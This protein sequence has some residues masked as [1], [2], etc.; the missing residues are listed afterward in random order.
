[1]LY[2]AET[3]GSCR[4]RKGTTGSGQSWQRQLPAVSS[5]LGAAGLHG[6]GALARCHTTQSRNDQHGESPCSIRVRFPD[7]PLG[8]ACVGVPSGGETPCLT[9]PLHPRTSQPG[10]ALPNSGP[11]KPSGSNPGG[12]TVRRE[13][14]D[15]RLD[16]PSGSKSVSISQSGRPRETKRTSRGQFPGVGNDGYG[17]PCGNRWSETVGGRFFQEAA[18]STIPYRARG[19]FTVFSPFF[20]VCLC[21]R[22]ERTIFL[23]ANRRSTWIQAQ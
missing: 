3:A 14:G 9:T 23:L 6:W 22:K 5:F 19:K 7:A 1:M 17:R 8:V 11:G 2:D 18:E 15:Y 21:A 4:A 12:G 16:G 10:D 13:A 20:A